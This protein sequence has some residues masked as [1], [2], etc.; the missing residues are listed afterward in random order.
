MVLLFNSRLKLFLGK[1]KSKWS[2]PFRISQVYSSGVVELEDIDGGVFKE[3]I[4]PKYFDLKVSDVKDGKLGMKE[5]RLSVR[6]CLC[7]SRQRS[8]Q[9]L[10]HCLCSLPQLGNGQGKDYTN[11]GNGQGKAYTNLGNNIGVANANLGKAKGAAYAIAYDL[12]FNLAVA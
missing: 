8:R 1:L 11:L 6:H 2:G 7:E 10:C 9:G 3:G 12:C 5:Q 4:P